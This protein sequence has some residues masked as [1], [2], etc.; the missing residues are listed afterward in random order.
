MFSAYFT[1][2]IFYTKFPLYTSGSFLIYALPQPNLIYIHTWHLSS[3]SDIGGPTASAS[4]SHCLFPITNYLFC[5]TNV[6]KSF[7]LCDC[8]NGFTNW[9]NKLIQY[10]WYNTN[11]SPPVLIGFPLILAIIKT[12]SL[13]AL[14]KY[15]I[16]PLELVFFN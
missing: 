13:I 12:N 3:S 7:K 16:K 8:I 14:S 9:Y 4:T 2:C 11:L 5:L 1:S 15:L 6:V 10:N